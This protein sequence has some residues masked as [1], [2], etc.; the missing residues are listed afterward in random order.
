V[1]SYS[2]RFH[3]AEEMVVISVKYML[4]LSSE[5]TDKSRE[6]FVYVVSRLEAYTSVLPI[7][8]RAA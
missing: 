2:V 6:S 8:K 7:E 3:S 4:S 5:R 1:R